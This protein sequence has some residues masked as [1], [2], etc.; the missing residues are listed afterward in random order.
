MG[1][2]PELTWIFS[3]ICKTIHIEGGFC[4]SSLSFTDVSYFSTRLPISWILDYSVLAVYIN[5][6]FLHCLK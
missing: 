2:Y 4:I 1:V 3:F 5:I 6:T